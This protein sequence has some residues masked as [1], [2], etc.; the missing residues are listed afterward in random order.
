MDWIGIVVIIC[1]VGLVAFSIVYNVRKRKKGGGCC[2]GSG[3]GGACEACRACADKVEKADG[4][5]KVDGET[6]KEE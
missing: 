1:A 5:E 2:E 4:E 3:S 6:K